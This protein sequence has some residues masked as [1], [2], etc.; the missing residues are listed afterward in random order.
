MDTIEMLERVEEAVEAL[1]GHDWSVR[2]WE[3]G[4][5]G[6]ARAYLSRTLSRGRRQDVGYIELRLGELTYSA[7]RCRATVRD[8]AD[9]VE[10]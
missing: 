5:D 8:I 4:E 1:E 2:L 9:Q 3:S 6:Y 7:D 10:E